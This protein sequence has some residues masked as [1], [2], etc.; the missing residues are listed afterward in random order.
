MSHVFQLGAGSGGM[1][2]LDLIARDPAVTRV[3][4]IEPDVYAA[5][6]VHRHLFPPAAVGRLKADLATEWLR[7]LRPDLQVTALASDITDPTRQAEFA[8]LAAECDVGVCA[9]DNEAAKF[10]FDALMR[11]TGKPWTLGEVLSGGIGGWVHRFVPSG[12]CYGCVASHLKREVTEQPAGPP[13][14]Y[15][16]PNGTQPETTIPA[17]KASIATVAGLHALVTLGEIA[18]RP[19]IDFTSMLFSLQTVTGVFD[20]PFRAHRMK[21]PRSPT[22]LTCGNAKPL[23]AGDALDAALADALGRLGA[24]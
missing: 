18:S 6:N 14:D 15:S 20:A 9:A 8:A 2:V 23:P 22:C 3:T 7:A 5:H 4:L 24:N 21:V 11:T 19:A 16:N 13:P 1:A 17:G 10:A 12:A